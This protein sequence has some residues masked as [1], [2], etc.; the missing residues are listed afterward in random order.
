MRRKSLFA[1][2]AI[3]ALGVVLLIRNFYSDL[4]FGRLFADYWPWLLIG[5][6]AFRL[7]EDGAARLL[8]RPA[9][10]AAGGGAVVL[11]LALCAAGSVTHAWHH[12]EAAWFEL[13]WQLEEVLG[14]EHEYQMEHGVDL[15]EASEVVLNG[16]RGRL[17]IRGDDSS[18]LRL[19]GSKIVRAV[20]SATA[21]EART[22]TETVSSLEDGRLVITASSTA[23]RRGIRVRRRGEMSLPRGATLRIEDYSG[24]LEIEDI[25]GPVSVSGSTS[26]ELRRIGG[27]VNAKLRGNKKLIAEDLAAGLD[28]DGS[29]RQVELRRVKGPVRLE[30]N[31]LRQV[32]MEEVDGRIEAISRRRRL[33][34]A[35]LPGSLE[36]ESGSVKLERPNGPLKLETKKPSQIELSEWTGEAEIVA[37]RGRIKLVPSASG[38]SGIRARIQRGDI[39]AALNPDQ[40]IAIEAESERGEVRN[41]L[42]AESPE[43]DSELAIEASAAAPRMELHTRRGDIR[44]VRAE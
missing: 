24:E 5:W 35:G 43:K 21:D 34:C 18:A 11:A 44:L 33:L 10:R 1:P 25:D 4:S 20:D 38:W 2:L 13:P 37:E 16:Y 17:T 9:P 32:E 42:L 19:R 41:E 26:V 15:A 14:D 6:G 22:V 12:K 7:I 27:D 39:E 36:W 30:G 23:Q 28:L 31:L 3:I 8:D 29:M 40:N